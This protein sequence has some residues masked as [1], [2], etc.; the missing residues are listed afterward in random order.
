MR[1]PIP[2]DPSV[3]QIPVDEAETAR[4]LVKTLRGITSTTLRNGGKPLRG[5]H[6]KSHALLDGEIE[7]VAGLPRDYA[8]GVFAHPGRLAAVMRFSTIPGDLLD[9]SVSTPRGVAIKLLQVAGERLEG[10]ENDT[11]Q[12]FILVNGPAFGAPDPKAF[13]KGLKL[14][15]ATT[16]RVQGLKKAL[17]AVMRAVQS[18][19]VRATGSPSPLVATLGGQPFTHIL[20]ETFFSQTPFRY[21][22]FVAKFRLRPAS[23]EL[24]D[25]SGKTLTVGPNALRDA[26]NDFFRNTAAAWDFQVQLRTDADAM[27]VEDASKAWPEGDSP[28]VTVA[29]LRAGPQ[30]AWDASRSIAIDDGMSFSP[31]LGVTAHQPLGGVNRVRRPAYASG[32]EFRSRHGAFVASDQPDLQKENPQN[33]QRHEHDL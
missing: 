30:V 23:P 1:R 8:Q 11:T 12:D 28:F 17:S 27:P 33:I 19:I 22:D 3:E 21:G 6:A 24:A 26:C 4:S 16:D 15:A 32:R 13:A 9:D 7:V 14:L 20:G 25:L 18:L 29:R 31:W 5:V 10:S 2:Y